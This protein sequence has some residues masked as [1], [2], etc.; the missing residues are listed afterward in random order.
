MKA[1][2]FFNAANV[3]DKAFEAYKAGKS[4]TIS[5]ECG[6]CTCECEPTIYGVFLR[7]WEAET[8]LDCED[9]TSFELEVEDIYN[10]LLDDYEREA[11]EEEEHLSI[12][13]TNS[14]KF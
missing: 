4:I 3:A 9:Q 14:Y 10:Q 2:D 5:S 6:Q 8:G 11:K 7:V 13:G 1:K 12:L